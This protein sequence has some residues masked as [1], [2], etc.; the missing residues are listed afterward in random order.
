MSIKSTLGSI[1]DPLQAYLELVSV[2]WGPSEGFYW[3]TELWGPIS[4]S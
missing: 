2:R 4:T 3:G 1:D